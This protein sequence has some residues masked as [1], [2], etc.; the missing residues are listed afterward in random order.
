VQQ[1]ALATVQGEAQVVMAKF[2]GKAQQVTA[3]VMGA[4][5]APG[6]P[7]AGSATATVPSEMQSGLA[8]NQNMGGGGQGTGVD[9]QHT[10]VM[11]AQQYMQL[12]PEEQQMALQNL[13]AQSPD[14]AQLVL[15]EVH[16]LQAQGQSQNQPSMGGALGAAAAGVDMR[17]LPEI[18]P[19][20]R[21]AALI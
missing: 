11:L 2:Q 6:E 7:G 10:A 15:Q 13:E 12:G 4:A 8:A 1:I 16:R 5:A 19:P 3:S 9:L 17:P 21:M 18:L 14:L 20:R